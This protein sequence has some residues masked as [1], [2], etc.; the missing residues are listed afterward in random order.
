[1]SFAGSFLRRCGFHQFSSMMILQFTCILARRSFG[2]RVNVQKAHC[3]DD[4]IDAVRIRNQLLPCWHHWWRESC[5]YCFAELLNPLLDNGICLHDS[6]GH[7]LML[8]SLRSS[9]FLLWTRPGKGWRWSSG[10]LSALLE[11]SKK[12]SGWCTFVIMA[13]RRMIV[14]NDAFIEIWKPLALLDESIHCCCLILN[15]NWSIVGVVPDTSMTTQFASLSTHWSSGGDAPC[16]ITC[17][18]MKLIY[19]C[20]CASER[21]MKPRRRVQCCTR[22]IRSEFASKKKLIIIHDVIMFSTQTESTSLIKWCNILP[23]C[24]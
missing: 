17:L 10:L 3:Q 22:R 9:V 12:W 7:S 13:W 21:G 23:S 20:S 16:S 6:L 24:L 14:L 5:L 15:S 8:C 1:M 18:W 11:W 2:I 19:V 4:G